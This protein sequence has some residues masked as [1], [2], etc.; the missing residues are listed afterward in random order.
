MP[1]GYT[2]KHDAELER[3]YGKWVLVRR[4]LGIRSFGI[5][6]VEL[7]HGEAIPEHHELDRGHEEIFFVIEGAPTITIDNADHA[8]EAGAFVRLAPEPMRTV[9]NDGD[10]VARVISCPRR[11]TAATSP[12]T[13]PSSPAAASPAD[14]GHLDVRPAFRLRRS[15][16]RVAVT[17]PGPRRPIVA[18][19]SSSPAPERTSALR[20]C[21]VAANRHVKRLPSAEMRAREQSPQNGCVTDAI[22][23]ISPSPSR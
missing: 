2:I 6:I 3:D 13:G 14:I 11:P 1:D 5:N 7:A 21:P 18:S 9:R 23:P 22:T 20:S 4:S 10:G 17:P 16:L 19:S 12:W 8:L 15:D